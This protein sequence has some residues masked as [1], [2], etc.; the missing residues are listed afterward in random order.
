MFSCL[1][2]SFNFLPF[3]SLDS[4]KDVMDLLADML[5]AVNPRD[6]TVRTKIFTK[7]KKKHQPFFIIFCFVFAGGER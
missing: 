6:P 4:L 1:K 7:K 3:S 5:H 2:F